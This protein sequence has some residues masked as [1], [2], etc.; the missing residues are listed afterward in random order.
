MGESR[1]VRWAGSTNS[2]NAHDYY[3][4]LERKV[5]DSVH[6]RRVFLRSL[7]RAESDTDFSRTRDRSCT[8]PCTD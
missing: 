3:V 2:P 6:A 4:I 1:V 7:I 8:N 5:P